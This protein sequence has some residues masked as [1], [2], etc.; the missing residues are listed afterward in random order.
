MIDS[1]GQVVPAV[2]VCSMRPAIMNSSG[3]LVPVTPV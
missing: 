2:T 3:I 1:N